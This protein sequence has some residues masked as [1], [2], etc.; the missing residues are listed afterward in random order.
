M[1]PIALFFS[2]PNPQPV[3]KLIQYMLEAMASCSKSSM[4]IGAPGLRLSAS[5]QRPG[6][7][8]SV[9]RTCAKKRSSTSSTAGRFARHARAIGAKM[10]SRDLRTEVSLLRCKARPSAE[11]GSLPEDHKDG[12]TPIHPGPSHLLLRTSVIG[13]C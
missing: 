3:P 7:P 2:K 13:P 9:L 4:P 1:R 11:E 12:E 6:S 8:A 5:L 10:S